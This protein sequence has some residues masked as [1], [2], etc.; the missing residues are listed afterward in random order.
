MRCLH[1]F[2]ICFTFSMFPFP[3]PS[4]IKQNLSDRYSFSESSL[5]FTKKNYNNIVQIL[6]L[7]F[8]L[9]TFLWLT[10]LH[11]YSEV[12]YVAFNI[13]LNIYNKKYLFKLPTQFFCWHLSS[14]V[15]MLFLSVCEKEQIFLFFIYENPNPDFV[16]GLQSW[17]KYL[18]QL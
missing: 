18:A 15:V 11:L 12:K 7:T 2:I 9:L 13:N 8:G 14:T 4:P 5:N 10:W 6:I 17:T 16:L 3:S 1:M